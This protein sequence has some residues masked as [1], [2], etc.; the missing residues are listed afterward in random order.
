[1]TLGVGD[2]APEISALA[3]DGSRIA[4]KDL[5]GKGPVVLYFYPKDET[6]G[7]TAEACAFRD[8][9]DEVLAAGAVV[10]GVSSDSVESHASFR[11]HHGLPFKL[12]SDSD[13]RIRDAY[14]VRGRL[15]QP[16]VTF[17][18]DDA[19]VIRHVFASQLAPTRHVDE[20]LS[21]IR[22]IHEGIARRSA[23]PSI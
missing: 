20:A 7:C 3:D 8:S 23:S 6:M 22:D 19:G 4:L 13:K 14:G 18:I 2:R 21:A 5:I 16:R 12:V 15:L 9:W 10:I 17:V 1:M 11:K